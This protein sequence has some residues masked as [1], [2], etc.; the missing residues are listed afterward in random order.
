MHWGS[1]TNFLEMGGYAGFVWS[2]YVVTAVLIAAE[3]VSL[4]VQRRGAVQEVMRR[5][6]TREGLTR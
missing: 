3:V 2:A 4:R 1:L 5:A 6:Q